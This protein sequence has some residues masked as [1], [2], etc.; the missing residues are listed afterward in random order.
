VYSLITIRKVKNS[1]PPKKQNGFRFYTTVAHKLS[2][3]GIPKFPLTNKTSSEIEN[4]YQKYNKV[5]IQFSVKTET[6]T[7][8]ASVF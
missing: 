1:W 8:M 6:R 5:T 3:T 7:H 2:E 4:F